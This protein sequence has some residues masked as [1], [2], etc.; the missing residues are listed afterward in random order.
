MVFA[1]RESHGISGVLG[2]SALGLI[3]AMI[4]EPFAESCPQDL[5]LPTNI[6]VSA[7]ST[8][9]E[10]AKQKIREIITRS[11]SCAGLKYY[12]VRDA[13]AGLSRDATKDLMKVELAEL[14]LI[15]EQQVVRALQEAGIPEGARFCQ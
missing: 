8:L 4:A 1:L 15:Q 2:T 11:V 7:D 9:S 14:L 3:T 12:V 13:N 5:S 10:D 6:T